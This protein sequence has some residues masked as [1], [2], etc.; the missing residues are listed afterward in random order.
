[1]CVA[2][3]LTRVSP[4]DDAVVADIRPG[5][6]LGERYQIRGLIARGGMATVYLAVDQRLERTVALKVMHPA[7]ASDPSFVDRFVREALSIA[8]LSHPNVVAVYDQGSHHGLAY[9]VMEYVQGRTLR[10]VLASRGRLSPA[11]A[12][13]VLDPLLAGLAAAHRIGMVHRDVKPENVLIGND[14][15]VKVADFGLARIAESSRATTK[16]VMMATVAYVAPEIVTV[17][18]SDPRADVYAAGIVLF[19]ML[20]GAPPFQGDSPVQVAYQHVH[21]EMPAPAD[22]MPDIPPAL[23]QLAVRA[24]RRDPDERPVDAAAMLADLRAASAGPMATTVPMDLLATA[25]VSPVPTPQG[26][27]DTLLYAPPDQPGV[28]RRFLPRRVEDSEPVPDLADLPR[29]RSRWPARAVLIGAVLATVLV[30]AIG[31]GWWSAASGYTQVPG[32]VGLAQAQAEAKIRTAHL[33]LQYGPALYNETAPAGQVLSQQ[34]ADG[35]QVPK[36]TPITLVLSKGPERHG[37]PAVVGQPKD[38]AV[39]AIRTATLTPQTSTAYDE[40]VPAGNVV[41]TDPVAGTPLRRGAAVKVVVSK[42]PQPVQN[43]L[44]TPA[45]RRWAPFLC[46]DGNNSNGDNNNGNSGGDGTDGGDPTN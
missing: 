13:G 31:I 18:S 6:V 28:E 12:A 41:S 19:E 29:E 33:G 26:R 21:S 2:R 45:M 11:E 10:E 7:Y 44:C 39:Q 1:M 27:H 36:N 14:G 22:R 43:P 20:T 17:G 32:V 23:D 46:Q 30:V 3:M 25:P 34:P 42:G 35:A 40:N 9:L 5:A 37:V 4:V 16:G 15:T 24:T 8:R 38:T